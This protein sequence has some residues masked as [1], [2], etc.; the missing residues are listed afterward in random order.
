MSTE[1]SLEKNEKKSP[2]LLKAQASLK[3]FFVFDFK[4][5]NGDQVLPCD[6]VLYLVTAKKIKWQR[7]FSEIKSEAAYKTF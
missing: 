6:V 1:R 5:L 7:V 4:T 3:E 2:N